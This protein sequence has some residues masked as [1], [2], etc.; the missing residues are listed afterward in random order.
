MIKRIVYKRE[1]CINDIDV[2][3]FVPGRVSARGRTMCGCAWRVHVFTVAFVLAAHL[4]KGQSHFQLTKIYL[5]ISIK[6]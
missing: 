3:R 1:Y 4:I 5:F 6:T 2:F